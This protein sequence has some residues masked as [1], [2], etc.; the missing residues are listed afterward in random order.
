MTNPIQKQLDI[1]NKICSIFFSVPENFD[2]LVFEYRFDPE[3]GW[4]GTKLTTLREGKPIQTTL[5]EQDEYTLE[6]LCEKL[7]DEMQAHTGGDWRKFTLTIDENGEA[8]TKFSYEI[9][10]ISDLI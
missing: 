9:I 2:S 6:E 7:H 1:L 3:E 8:K 10:S 4:S 5:P